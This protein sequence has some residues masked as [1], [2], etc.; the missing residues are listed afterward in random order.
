[1]S[2][3][4]PC[5]TADVP[6]AG[7]QDRQAEQIP[8]GQR[9]R[10]LLQR[11]ADDCVQA[12]IGNGDFLGQGRGCEAGQCQRPNYVEDDSRVHYDG[13]TYGLSCLFPTPNA[14]KDP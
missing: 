1:M 8:L 13:L 7:F 14:T 9:P 11:F 2:R 5:D 4:Q 6:V 3:F 12:G 10:G